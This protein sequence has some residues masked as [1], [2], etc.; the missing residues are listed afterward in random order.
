MI[1]QL[2]AAMVGTVAFALLFSVPRSYYVNVGIIGTIG[3]A[4][5]LLLK[6][7]LYNSFAIVLSTV[8]VV[9]LS[10]LSAVI[11][12][13]PA[14]IFI[15]S[16][17]FPLIPG[18]G[19]Y[20]TTYYLVVNEP[21]RAM[22]TGYSALKAAVAIVLGIVLVNILPQSLFRKNLKVQNLLFLYFYF[23]TKVNFQVLN[24]DGQH[25]LNECSLKH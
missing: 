19:I 5:Y 9:F 4:S 25:L 11:R 16:G 23:E 22:S 12:R 18:G 14:T 8:I 15:I 6:E 13:C 10:R 21:R 17:L 2:I 20:W 3:W 24:H 1:T 7:V